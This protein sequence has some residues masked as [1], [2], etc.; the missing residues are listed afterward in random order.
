MNL[1]LITMPDHGKTVT[2]GIYNPDRK[3]IQ[4]IANGKTTKAAKKAAA[5]VFRELAK[6]C[7]K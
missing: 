3:T 4:H 7:E 2:V 5:K 1:K 6:E